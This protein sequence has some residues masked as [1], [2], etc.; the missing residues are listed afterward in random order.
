MCILKKSSHFSKGEHISKSPHI[1]NFCTNNGWWLCE[2]V[3]LKCLCM[4]FQF[5]ILFRSNLILNDDVNRALPTEWI[6]VHKIRAIG[7]FDYARI[8]SPV[9]Y[10]WFFLLVFLI[11]KFHFFMNYLCSLHV[12]AD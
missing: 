6:D 12:K 2:S 8:S 5:E 4:D 11:C 9:L 7:Y 10:L 1:G 3:E